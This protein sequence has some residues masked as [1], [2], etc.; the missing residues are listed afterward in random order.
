MLDIKTNLVDSQQNKSFDLALSLVCMI[1]LQNSFQM[2]VLKQG[3]H[4]DASDIK[5]E[6]ADEPTVVNDLKQEEASD[7]KQEVADVPTVANDIKQE[8]LNDGFENMRS[9]TL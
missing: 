2:N 1:A 5:Q 8:E 7:K 3:E 9:E 6:L 4:L